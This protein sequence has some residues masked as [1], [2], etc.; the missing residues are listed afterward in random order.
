MHYRSINLNQIHEGYHPRKDFTGKEKLKRS[1]EKYKLLEPIL[2]RK[3]RD[4][5][6]VIDGIMRLRVVK[7][8]GW[9]E[10][11]CNILDVDEE[12]SYHISYIK[13][14]QRKNLSPIEE[15]LH[16]QTVKE[17]F[18]YNHED[19]VKLG[20][21]PH[22]STLDDKIGLL[23]LPETIQN[24]IA[25]G[26]VI[27]PSIGYALCELKDAD[28]QV[29]LA[30]EIIARG[31]MSVR[32]VKDKVKSLNDSRKGHEEEKESPPEIPIGEIPG[33]FIKDAYYMSEIKDESVGLIVTSPP[34]GVG[35]EYE[36]GVN[37]E[38]HLENLERVFSKSV[39][40]ILRKHNMRLIDTII[41]KKCTKGKRDFN[42]SS[43]PQANY[44]DK[45][46]HTTYR[47]VNNTE[48]IHVY[49]KDGKR[50]V[51]PEIEDRSRVSKEEYDEWNDGVWEI[52]TVQ[53][54]KGHPAPFPE[55]IPR[56]LIKLYSYIG[57]IVLDP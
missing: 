14:T 33:V 51:T 38:K 41:W 8:L 48:Y 32:K 40:E 47:I 27:G 30:E 49:E 5:Y 37:F 45:K 25:E 17:K 16:L 57:D 35:L 39:R 31:G 10:I 6:I 29:K 23:T 9:K 15:A 28:L 26:S 7:E 50:D 11:T 20:Y 34:Y 12:K 42:W 36:K 4:K 18:G 46:R 21:A 54:K 22:R 55:E 52:H 1:I 44:H 13:N 3:D 43:N 19:L 2:V 56:R 53:G 24:S